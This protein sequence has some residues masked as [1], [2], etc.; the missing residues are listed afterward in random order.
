MKTAAAY[1]E[2]WADDWCTELDEGSLDALRRAFQ[3]AM[4]QARAECLKMASGIGDSGLAVALAFA[5]KA[6]HE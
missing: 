5:L 4:D 1:A 3:A 2:C 6:K